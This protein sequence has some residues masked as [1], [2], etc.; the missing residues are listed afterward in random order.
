MNISGFESSFFTCEQRDDVSILT[1]NAEQ[2]TEDE[3]LELLDHDLITLIDTFQVRKLIMNLRSVR[4][5][6]SS[7]IGKL[8]ATHRRLSRSE[9]RVFF[10]GLQKDVA[11]ILKTAHLFD[12]FNVADSNDLAAAEL[13]IPPTDPAV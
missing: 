6:T 7:A 3:N 8:I 12:Y 4:Y 1:M 5:M 11:D 9:G 2:L 13:A 10:T